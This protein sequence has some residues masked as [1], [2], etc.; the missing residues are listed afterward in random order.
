LGGRSREK[1]IEDGA[2]C[3]DAAIA[4]ERPAAADF[5]HDGGVAFDDERFF[6]IVRGFGE[7]AAEGIADEGCA[8]EF[9]ASLERA[10]EADSVGSRHVDSAGDGVGAH[11][12]APGVVLGFSVLRFFGGVPADGGGVEDYIG[13]RHGGEARGFGIPLVP[14]DQGGD[15]SEFC[16]EGA[17]AEVARGEVEF[18]EEE[19][20]VGDVHL[21]IETEER[22]IGVDD[23]GGVVVE[24]GGAFFEKG[25]HDDDAKFGGEWLETLGGRAGDG[26]GEIEE[27]GV[28]FAAEVLGAEKF[29]GADDLRATG[30]GFADFFDSAVE[31]QGGGVIRGARGLDKADGE[32]VGGH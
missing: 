28:F 16:V 10:F 14:A 12:C 5:F 29:L 7:D 24:A 4:Q 31:V 21:A 25:C 17:E 1:P 2:V 9:E 18:F 13:A 32:F 20:I 22:A 8:P 19:R 3:V 26:F 30:G 15:A 6:F 23:D 27:A 11:H